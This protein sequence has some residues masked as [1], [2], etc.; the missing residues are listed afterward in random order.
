VLKISELDVS[1]IPPGTHMEMT[2]DALPGEKFDGTLK[3]INSRETTVDGVP[4]YE[5][6]VELPSDNRIKT[7]M[8]ANG[9]VVLETKKDV[10]A[11]PSYLIQKSGETNMVQVLNEK[12][13]KEERVVTLGLLG[14]DSMVEILSGLSEGDRVVSEGTSK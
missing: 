7:G 9:V 6:F 14:T 12:N 13:N 3:T 1:R 2:L 8:S 11:I 4:V 5:A 10:L